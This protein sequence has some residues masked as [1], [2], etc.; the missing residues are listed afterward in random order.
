MINKFTVAQL[1]K[2]K[3]DGKIRGF[4]EPAPVSTPNGKIVAKHFKRRSKEKEF[5]ALNLFIWCQSRSLKLLEEFRFDQKGERNFQFDWCI[6]DIKVAVE[7]EGLMS[8][9]SGHT[10]VTGYT[11]DVIKYNLATSQGWHVI[12]LTALNYQSLITELEKCV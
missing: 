5:I 3:A 4:E 2:L 1:R 7:Y 11:K 10:T 8:E 9:K 12:R 6:P